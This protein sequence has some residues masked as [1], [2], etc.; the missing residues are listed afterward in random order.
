VQLCLGKYAN[1][2]SRSPGLCGLEKIIKI[3]LYFLQKIDY[4]NFK[5]GEGKR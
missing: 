5:K 2:T 1:P 3:W 4:N